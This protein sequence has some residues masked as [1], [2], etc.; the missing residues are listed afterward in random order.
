MVRPHST[1]FDL[2][3]T[4]VNWVEKKYSAGICDQPQAARFPAAAV[5]FVLFPDMRNTKGKGDPEK[6]ENFVCKQ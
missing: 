1:T 4:A 2:L 3:T 6:A 5:L